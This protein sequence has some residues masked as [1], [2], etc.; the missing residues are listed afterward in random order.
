MDQ[1]LL[2]FVIKTLLLKQT[3]VYMTP[4]TST[5]YS[6]V[7]QPSDCDLDDE[8]ITAMRDLI[9]D[10]IKNN[11][12]AIADALI[13]RIKFNVQMCTSDVVFELCDDVVSP[14]TSVMTN[15][16][17]KVDPRLSGALA[18]ILA[19]GPCNYLITP[20]LMNVPKETM[21][22]TTNQIS[23]HLTNVRR[24]I[25]ILIQSILS[26][27]IYSPFT[28][29]RNCNSKVVILHNGP[30]KT[31]LRSM[32]EKKKMIV[33]TDSAKGNSSEPYSRPEVVLLLMLNAYY[34]QSIVKDH[35]FPKENREYLKHR[36]ATDTVYLAVADYINN[37][38][39]DYVRFSY[40][41]R[42]ELERK[43][44][45]F[46]KDFDEYLAIIHSKDVHSD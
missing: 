29:L 8:T 2:S 7:P 17:T 23:G 4:A 9:T 37:T 31:E 11:A 46:L 19:G 5:G 45:E 6:M 15:R 39:E 13:E 14:C 27:E 1:K 24:S 18:G 44:P 12:N 38:V 25:E 16:V 10:R 34:S 3:P 36:W 40:S 26:E 43:A 30:D 35:I 22:N 33:L 41:I 20:A 32:A 21:I 28:A 42:D